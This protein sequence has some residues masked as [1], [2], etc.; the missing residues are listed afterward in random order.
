[1]GSL[2][3]GLLGVVGAVAAP[4]ESPS[5]PQA[6]FCVPTAQTSPKQQPWQSPHAPATQLPFWQ[7]WPDGQAW[8]A[9][10]LTPHACDVGAV[11]H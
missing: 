2:A 9:S 3:V 7:I 10:P 6:V 1:M 11:T 5:A 4:Q 8:H